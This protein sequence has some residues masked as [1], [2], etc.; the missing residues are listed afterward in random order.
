[1]VGRFYRR[2]WPGY[3]V[4]VLIVAFL[5][6]RL[7]LDTDRAPD[8]LEEGNYSVQ[9]V[10]DGDTLLL[11]N[12]ARVR[13]QGIDCP[14]SV[15][16]DHPVEAWGPEAADFTRDF[17]GTGEVRLRFDRERIDQYGRFLAYVYVDD[18]MLNEQLVRAGLA[19]FEPGFNYS[20]SMK[21]LLERAEEEA[22]AQRR[23]IWSE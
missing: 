19:T 21:R 17:L 13:L 14:E 23:G 16:P 8:A 2:R 9:R 20:Y 6:A 7:L 22:K 4:T 1:M 5:A 18:R 3:L 12:G 10:V 11:A 15:K